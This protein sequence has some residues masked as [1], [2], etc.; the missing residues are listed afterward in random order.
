MRIS[1]E[2]VLG[3]L[4]GLLSPLVPADSSY[5]RIPILSIAAVLIVYAW[6]SSDIAESPVRRV[7]RRAIKWYGAV[8]LFGAMALFG[9]VTW[10]D[11]TPTPPDRPIVAIQEVDAEQ[12]QAMAESDSRNAGFA[13]RT[14]RP[15]YLLVRSAK[16]EGLF[17]GTKNLSSVIARNVVYRVELETTSPTGSAMPVPVDV[18]A[19]A[20][21]VLMPHQKILRSATFPHGTIYTQDAGRARISITVYFS[22]DSSDANRYFY[23]VVLSTK[24]YA[25]PEAMSRSGIGGM[26]V[27][28]TDEGIVER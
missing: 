26:R 12:I 14:Y 22:G 9:Y 28:S 16:T 7:H 18:G 11:R 17:Y 13:P 20:P 21:D 23:T 27:E 2:G 24:R 8:V 10:P 3:L 4:V 1:R 5:V 6:W 19:S 15:G 25:T